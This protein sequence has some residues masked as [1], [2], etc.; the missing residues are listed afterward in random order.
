MIVLALA[1]CSVSTFNLWVDCRIFRVKEAGNDESSIRN[2]TVN[3][4]A[5]FQGY[6]IDEIGTSE[7][8]TEKGAEEWEGFEEFKFGIRAYQRI[9]TDKKYNE[10]EECRDFDSETVFL[11]EAEANFYQIVWLL[12]LLTVPCGIIGV[13]CA[14]VELFCCV[15]YPSVICGAIFLSMAACTET[16][17]LVMYVFDHRSCI[18][19]RNCFV[20]VSFFAYLFVIGG[21]FFSSNLLIFGLRTYPWC[22]RKNRDPSHCKVVEAE[23]LS[24]DEIL[25]QQEKW[26]ALMNLDPESTLYDDYSVRSET[27]HGKLRNEL[28]NAQTNLERSE[29]ERLEAIARAE[30]A[31]AMLRAYEQKRR[32][33]AVVKFREPKD[34]ASVVT[35]E[36]DYI[37]AVAYTSGE[38]E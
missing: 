11:T 14:M 32:D 19:D 21:F 37:D 12:S 36:S 31:E 20:D 4:D 24:E 30:K 3:L 35:N 33:S 23:I 22:R 5:F 6:A 26:D 18:I 10:Q 15:F 1:A 17:W 27:S 16:A 9:D 2:F 28:Q 29:Q 34:A 13:L 25:R 7:N 8:R 38:E